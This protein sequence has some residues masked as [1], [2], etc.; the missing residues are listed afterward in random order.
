ELIENLV[1]KKFEDVE[2]SSDGLACLS[3]VSRNMS[4]ESEALFY[5]LSGLHVLLYRNMKD[6]NQDLDLRA[7][8]VKYPFLAISLA[9]ISEK[10]CG[11][12]FNMIFF[13]YCGKN[14]I[15][16]DDSFDNT[17]VTEKE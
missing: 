1:F 6:L 17:D 12:K 10:I 7:V 8:D 11:A 14:P 4:L 16:K 15:N 9:S 13:E 3:L 2:I 5:G